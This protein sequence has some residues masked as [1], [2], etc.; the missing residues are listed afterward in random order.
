M[1]GGMTGL[2]GERDREREEGRKGGREEGRKGGR[3]EE[4]ERLYLA[5]SHNILGLADERSSHEIDTLYK[6]SIYTYAYIIHKIDTLYIYICVHNYLYIHTHTHTH[7]HTHMLV[8]V[9]V[10]VCACMC[11]CACVCVYIKEAAT[12]STPCEGRGRDQEARDLEHEPAPPHA[13][14]SC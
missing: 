7:T 4:K 5:D 11:V 14:K 12:N 8:H 3:E 13:D 6:T 10:W 2:W 9:C 1:C